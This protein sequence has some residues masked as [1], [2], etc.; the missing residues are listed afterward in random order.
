MIGEKNL[1]VENY[2]EKIWYTNTQVE[3]AD[4]SITKSVGKVIHRQGVDLWISWKL[5]KVERLN[6]DISMFWIRRH[7]RMLLC[8]TVDKKLSSKS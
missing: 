1:I 4:I 6:V 7:E 2:V 3:K 8:K 5:K